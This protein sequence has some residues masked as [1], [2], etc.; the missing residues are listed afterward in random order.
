MR[1][2][3]SKYQG[4]GNDFIII[5]NRDH[6][7]NLTQKQIAQ[8]CD[9]R[10]GVGADGL[11]LLE[12]HPTLDFNM[13]YFNSDGNEGSMCGNGGRCLVAFVKSLEIIDEETMF[14]TIDGAHHAFIKQ[15]DIVA[16]QMQDVKKVLKMDGN[17]FVNTGSPHYVI[18]SQNIKDIDVYTEGKKIRESALFAPK[19]TNV[20]FVEIN[21]NNLFVRTFERGVENETLSCGTGVT[22]AAICASAGQY[23]DKNSLDIITRGGK[24]N[25]RFQ[26]NTNHSYTHVWLTGPAKFVFKG[27]FEF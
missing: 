7:V 26:K 13:R 27:E 17:F 11:M 3:F 8:I 16:L 18:F 2:T 5:D 6:S 4:T 12:K 15:K 21:N 10:F 9:R 1:F 22:A 14:N 20:N 25:V 24:L 19:G 23:T